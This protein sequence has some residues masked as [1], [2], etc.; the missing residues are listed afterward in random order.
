MKKNGC[1]MPHGIATSAFKCLLMMKMIILL[2]CSF[3]LQSIANNGFAQ[4]RITLRLENST[5]RK[6][7][8]AIEKQTS[9]RFVY[10]EEVLPPDQ[11]VS[12][13]V[14][15][16]P[17]ND[18]MKQLLANTSLTYKIFGSDLIVISSSINDLTATKNLPAFDVKGRVVN[19]NNEPAA[20]VSVLEKG[21]T[22]G[23]ITKEDGSFSLTVAAGNSVLVVSS[24]GFVS[25]EI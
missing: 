15:S 17:V 8:K 2:V 18:V 19:S 12:I 11:K 16:E 14:Q 25:Q 6:A 4:E 1:R 22:N 21:T 23:T 13:S 10:N 7:F 9:F 3:S 20:R 24:V 5:F